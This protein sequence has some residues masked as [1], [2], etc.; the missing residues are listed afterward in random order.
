M[1]P[2]QDEEDLR[3][4]IRLI[5]FLYLITDPYPQHGGTANSRRKKRRRWRRRWQQVQQLAER[6]LLD[7]TDPPVE[8]D[9]DAA[10]ADL[11][12]LQLNNLPEPPVDFS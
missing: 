10:I 12:K 5:N 1:L 2:G 8:Q 4:K 6:I 7:S 11:Q 9:L 3:K